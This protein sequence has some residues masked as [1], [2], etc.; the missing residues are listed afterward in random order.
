M[1]GRK[2]TINESF[3]QI[4]Q[5][6]MTFNGERAQFLKHRYGHVVD[7]AVANPNEHHLHFKVD[8][9]AVHQGLCYFNADSQIYFL[10][11]RR[12]YSQEVP[13]EIINMELERPADSSYSEVEFFVTGAGIHWII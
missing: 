3:E 5:K 2:R 7:Q 11:S 9:K 8:E 10:K 12:S 13:K 4:G 6:D 1:A